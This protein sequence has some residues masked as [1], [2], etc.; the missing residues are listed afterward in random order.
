M[1]TAV[2]TSAG[3]S[4]RDA[5][6]TF[7]L[8]LSLQSAYRRFFTGLGR[9]PDRLV[10]A[11][12]SA[13]DRRSN[14]VAEAG[15]VVIGHVMWSFSTPARDAVDVAVVVAD[16]HRRR[17]LG[18]ALIRYAVEAAASAGARRVEFTVLPDNEP[19]I[20]MVRRFEAVN[21]GAPT[22]VEWPPPRLV[23]GLLQF[24]TPILPVVA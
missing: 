14:F 4:T 12:T 1:T 8:G 9:V 22:N 11:L 15:G 10:T 5:M 24:S 7:L 16:E 13:D 2:I 17:G 6:R 23:D 18:S 20:A 19:A 21:R 3:P